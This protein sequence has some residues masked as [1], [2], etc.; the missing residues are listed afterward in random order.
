[1][2]PKL[3]NQWLS[4]SGMVALKVRTGGSEEPGIIIGSFAVHLNYNR[5]KEDKKDPIDSTAQRSVLSMGPW[6]L[7]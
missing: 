4:F 2:A 3:R 1:M 5:T 6:Q 7:K